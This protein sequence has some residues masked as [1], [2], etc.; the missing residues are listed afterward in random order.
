MKAG[1]VFLALGTIVTSGL[2]LGLLLG[3]FSQPDITYSE[4]NRSTPSTR[5]PA[6]VR[7]E[8]EVEESFDTA[9]SDFDPSPFEEGASDWE[10]D[11]S[12]YRFDPDFEPGED[13]Q[14]AWPV[15]GGEPGEADAP[16]LA[17][18][19]PAPVAPKQPANPASRYGNLPDAAR[20]VTA[21]PAENSQDETAKPPAREPRAA[22]GQLPAI[23]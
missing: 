9:F 22:D 1:K 20:P 15:G 7:E 12:I 14:F 6:T 23:W 21:N 11:L 3:R 4:P 18:K 17:E 8:N 2:L 10:E 5:A 19:P 16:P 13:V